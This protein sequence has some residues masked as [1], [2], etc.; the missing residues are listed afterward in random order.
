ML[1]Y[2]LRLLLLGSVCSCGAD[3]DSMTDAGSAGSDASHDASSSDVTVPESDANTS[4]PD[5]GMEMTGCG[6]HE[7]CDNGTDDD[8]DGTV[9]EGCPCIPG[10]VAA[11]F[12]GTPENRAV[13]VCADG[14][15]T[16]TD[17]LEFGTWGP[18]E[19]DT[20]PGEEVCDEDLLDED[21]DGA[22]NEGCECVGTEPTPCGSAEGACNQGQQL[23]IDGMR[24]E[25]TGATGPLA[26]VCNNADDDCDGMIDEFVS[27][28]CGTDMGECAAGVEVCVAG[29]FEGCS[30]RSGIDEICDNLD[31]D[32]DGMVDETL[33]RDCGSGV[34]ECSMGSQTCTEGEWG[35]CAGETLPTI[36]TCNNRDDDC[37]SMIDNG[38]QRPC[39]S[40][41]GI[42]TPGTEICSAGQWGACM[43]GETGRDEECDTPGLDEDCDGSAN[44]GCGCTDG[45]YPCG[46]NVGECVEGTQECAGGMLM[47]CVGDTPPATEEC[48]GL[49]DDCD[50]QVDEMGVC[51]TAPASGH[52]PWRRKHRSTRTGE[53]SG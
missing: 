12:R 49:D 25:C 48:N 35:N 9:E 5:S 6:D 36:E 29:D 37:D 33:S 39:G 34:G 13:G 53:L 19:G 16:C 7:I 4:R 23:C 50:R 18:C 15:M 14:V 11:C 30:G 24:G 27:R 17:G 1:R 51:P 3:G 41:V 22:E 47:A 45:T 28:N 2:G 40:S 38:V 10:A 8:C 46:T 31:N 32:C 20:R 44:E 42:C 52:M 26:E 43:G 21:C